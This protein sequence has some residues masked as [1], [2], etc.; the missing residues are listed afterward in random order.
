MNYDSP[1]EIA[2]SEEKLMQDLRAHSKLAHASIM[3]A[4]HAEKMSIYARFNHQI[5]VRDEAL[6]AIRYAKEVLAILFPEEAEQASNLSE[7]A[8][9]LR[10]RLHGAFTDKE[11][12]PLF[13]DLK[14]FLRQI[15]EKK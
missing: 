1:E 7:T 13:T 11:N 4:F 6:E 10:Y 9:S 12:T 3:C 14:K 15:E 8:R 5:D 2:S